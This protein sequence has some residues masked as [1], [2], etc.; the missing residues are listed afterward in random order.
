MNGTETVR[1]AVFALAYAGISVGRLP[2]RRLSRPAVATA[3]AAAM[4]L[5][6][7]LPLKDAV[8]AV[9]GAVLVLLL[10]FMLVVAQLEDAGFFHWVAR[11]VIH[12]ATTPRRLLAAV[13]GISGLL[14]ALFVNDT[15]CLVLTPLLLA[16]VGPLGA[17]AVPYLIAL[18][19]AA[20]V[21][22]VM[23]P[24]G[25]PQNMLVAVHGGFSFAAFVGRMA[26]A[27]L[28]GLV[29]TYGLLLLIFRKQLARPF[30]RV[31]PPSG[32]PP[33]WK[34]AT[35]VLTGLG[36]AIIAWLAGAPPA[37]VAAAA[38]VLALVAAPRR[39]GNA[40]RRTEWQ[41]LLFFAALFILVRGIEGTQLVADV[42]DAARARLW[43]PGVVRTGAVAGV[44]LVLGNL[45]SNVP[46]VMM[47]L[48]IVPHLPDPTHLW[49]VIAMSATF[50]GNLLL[51]GSMANLIVA[52]RAAARGI[53]LPFLAYARAGIPIT[54]VTI[55]WGALALVLTR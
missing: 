18:A 5:L 37:G 42:M 41:L 51:V 40:L 20:N 39:A 11:Q 47:W 3:G 50:A 29:I 30:E 26:P 43:H 2:G 36:V 35:R 53:T 38:G 4:I 32:D 12:R 17:P 48:P 27:G 10:G 31:A 23:T 25:N 8:R 54:F 34:R 14:S 22:S 21:G 9:D 46:G 24:M 13:V 33:D 7:G 16:V 1:L 44:T 52:E 45:V 19:T 28:G 55:A 49:L 15:V 6:G